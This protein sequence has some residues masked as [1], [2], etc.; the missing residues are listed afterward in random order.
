MTTHVSIPDTPDALFAWSTLTSV[1]N[2]GVAKS[3]TATLLAPVIWRFRRP[4]ITQKYRTALQT[5]C[6]PVAVRTV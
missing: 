5:C 6:T 1:M 2:I 4:R 3:L